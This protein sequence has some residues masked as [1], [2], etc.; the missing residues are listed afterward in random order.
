M[1]IRQAPGTNLSYFLIC[2]DK[3]GKERE[4][5]KGVYLSGSVL[6]A[7]RQTDSPVTD[8]FIISHGWK[9]DVPAAIEQY[10]KWIATMAASTAIQEHAEQGHPSFSPL[11]VG[12]HWPSLPWGDEELGGSGSFG[13]GE[14]GGLEDFVATYAE[15]IADSPPARAALETILKSTLLDMDPDVLSQDVIEAYKILER[16]AQLNGNGIGAEP[17]HDREIFDPDATYQQA[18]DIAGEVA[19]FGSTS[20]GS[21]FLAPLRQLSF[22]KMKDRARA[23]GETGAHAFLGK[24]QQNIESGRSIRIHTM[25]HSFGCIVVSA[26]ISGSPDA[27][28]LLKPVDSLMLIQGALSLWSYC[29]QIPSSPRQHGYFYPI[30]RDKRVLGPIVTTYSRFDTAVRRFYPLGARVSGH[31]SFDP[32]E[33]PKYGGLGTFGAHGEGIDVVDREMLPTNLEYDMQPGIIYNLNSD[34]YIRHGAGASG[35]HSDICHPEVAHA[36]WSAVSR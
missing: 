26:M 19:S 29:S 25:G 31:I 35:A 21:V 1:P 3:D 5:A 9:G 17:G 18:R 36:M 32:T 14:S 10:D 24:I 16:E 7:I 2:H 30:L 33:L 34:A 28:S 11:I 12:L 13:I 15:R 8:V 23:F 20:I 6:E 27:P 22:W 4:E